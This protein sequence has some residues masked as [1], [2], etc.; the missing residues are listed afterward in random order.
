MNGVQYGF[1]CLTMLSLSACYI[2]ICITIKQNNVI[3]FTLSQAA[4][5]FGAYANY[6]FTWFS[7]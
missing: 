1:L 2:V 3:Y 7:K 4:V 5:F 6:L